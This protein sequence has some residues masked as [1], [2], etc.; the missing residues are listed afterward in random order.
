M[1][2]SLQAFAEEFSDVQRR[3][4]SDPY[5]EVSRRE[6]IKTAFPIRREGQTS[7]DVLGGEIR[8]IGQ[9]FR[10]GHVRRQIVENVVDG[11]PQARDTRLTAH[12]VR[13]DGNDLA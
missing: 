4:I 6:R 1:S 3:P 2:R 10:L 8:K 12:L 7:A 9:N 5:R 13:L 11:D